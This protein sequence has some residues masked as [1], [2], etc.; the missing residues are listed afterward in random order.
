M[1]GEITSRKDYKETP[2][3]QQEYW[4]QELK[5]SE[6]SL[7]QFRKDGVKVVER[8][9]GKH[10]KKSVG[11]STKSSFQLNLFH[12]NVV[13]LLSMLY[14]N[15]PTVEVS[16]THDDFEDDVGRAASIMM[17][18]LLN[19]DVQENGH[20]YDSVL[21]ATLQDRLLPGLGC[22]R[23]RYDFQQDELGNL[24]GESAPVDYYHWNDV[25]WGWG[26]TFSEIP[27]VAFRSYL[28]KDEATDRFGEEKV[29]DLEYKAQKINNVD[30]NSDGDDSNSPWQ[31][32]EVWEIWDKTTKK[33][34]WVSLGCAKALDTKDD[35]LK[36]KGFYPCPPFF[37]ANQTTDCYVPVSDFYLSQDLYNE[38]DLLQNRISTLT[39]AVKVVGVYN[40]S[41]GEILANM[42]DEGKDNTLIPVSNWASFSEGGGL[43]GSIDWV[44]IADVVAAL[45]KLR[46]LRD[47]TIALLQQVTGMSDIMQGS[48]NQYEG[49][50]QASLKAKFGGIRI[51]ALQDQFAQFASDLMQLK[52]E[53]ISHHF[54][55][56]SI[57][58][59]SNAQMLPEA[60]TPEGQALVMQGAQLIK[61]P[62]MARLKIKIRPESV[63]MVDYSHLKQER[64]EYINA[65]A[66]FMQA[67]NPL[68]EADPAAK[69]FMLKLLQWG[70][71]GFKG[72]DAIEGVMDQAIKATE[73]QAE[74]GS[75]EEP[76]PEQVR[77]QAQQ[78]L[79]S[80]K[81]QNTMQAIEAK[82]RADLEV[83]AADSSADM[84][85]IQAEH[86]S[87]MAEIVAKAM[88]D[89]KVELAQS[90]LNAAQQIDGVRA[91][92]EKGQQEHINKLEE[93]T[94]G[95]A[96][97]KQEP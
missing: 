84:T 30:E 13:T 35:P 52:A 75:G 70:L 38:L 47:E 71:S 24:L 96:D 46:S 91:E 2:K 44:P 43:D 32:A 61:D 26:R 73:K 40:S 27:W 33:V 28:T 82:K 51:Q 64:T 62:A 57:I 21:R 95:K 8:F 86:Q 15:L 60:D 3:G 58:K 80:M 37:L 74:Q 90:Q 29:K 16:R 20:E 45:D 56:E 22:A 88:N 9:K 76:N 81:H 93:I 89:I 53:V 34:T 41:N 66:V 23:V 83:R 14:G 94:R 78:A 85:K 39:Q 17:S 25:L 59:Y 79:E 42:F 1:A 5:A 72:S 63:A 4:H 77:A 19:N 11:S 31:K 10:G 97:T 49:V 69:P 54:S 50:G 12:S 7:K 18:R 87:E 48:S 92:M 6:K 36:L 55:V 65:I 68:M 67:A